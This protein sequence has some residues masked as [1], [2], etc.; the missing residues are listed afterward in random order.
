[1]VLL[2]GACADCDGN[3]RNCDRHP[4]RAS[5]KATPLTGMITGS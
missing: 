5:A 4:V 2:A 1:M 3:C